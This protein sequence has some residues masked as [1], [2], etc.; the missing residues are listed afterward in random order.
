MS[1]RKVPLDARIIKDYKIMSSGDIASK[2]GIARGTVCKHLRRLKI[3]RPVRGANSR[4]RKRIGEVVKSGY[5]VYHLLTHPRASAIGYVFKHILEMEKY[6][7]RVPNKEEPIHHINLDR[8]NYHISNLFLTN[9]HSH[10]QAIHSSLDSC[11]R[12]LVQ[13]GILKFR[14]GKYSV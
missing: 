3:T 4:N 6:L 5:P 13:K 7:G 12:K 10:H 11:V 8:A 1:A 14:D 9:N 2:Y